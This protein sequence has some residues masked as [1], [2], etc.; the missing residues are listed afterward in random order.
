VK[1]FRDLSIVLL[2][3]GAL[4]PLHA[5]AVSIPVANDLTSDGV[6][7]RTRV[8]LTNPTDTNR[9]VEASFRASA[10]TA[11]ISSTFFVPADQ[12]VALDQMMAANETG[13]ITLNAEPQVIVTTRL[14]SLATDGSSL[15]GAE[16]PI[17]SQ[18]EISDASTT[19]ELQGVVRDGEQTWTNLG[20]TNFATADAQCSVEILSGEDTLVPAQTLTVAA[21]S[22]LK[23]DDVLG[24]FGVTTAADAVARV[25]CD[26]AFHAY[27][28]VY[29]PASGEV[30]TM[31]SRQVSQLATDPVV[32]DALTGEWWKCT[33]GDQLKHWDVKIGPGKVFKK[34]QVQI[35][36]IRG[37]WYSKM[38]DGM[39]ELFWINRTKKWRTNNLGYMNIRGPNKNIWYLSTNATGTNLKGTKNKQFP[40]GASYHVNYLLDTTQ[41]KAS[42]VI[43]DLAGNVFDSVSF[44]V[45]VSKIDSL[46]DWLIEVP[47][48]RGIGYEVPSWGWS[49][50]NLHV[51]WLP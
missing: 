33:Q 48:I 9:Q 29:T 27:A 37:P 47:Q 1:R 4:S 45:P 5:S 51:E 20:L 26:Q 17:I 23:L 14:G 49:F 46:G 34:L 19:V 35:D 32:F 36:F 31:V 8:F 30:R 41:K 42:I 43:S 2:L 12:T 44:S 13:L 24:Q 15:A 22:H 6:R 10:G 28:S 16:M 3:A 39:H 7:F 38:Q 21:G 25:S 50:S 18:R 40:E 11:T